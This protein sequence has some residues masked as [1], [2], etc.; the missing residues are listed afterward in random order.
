MIATA[1]GNQKQEKKDYMELMTKDSA[2]KKVI[3]HMQ[4]SGGDQ[5]RHGDDEHDV[6]EP[7]R[8]EN[9]ATQ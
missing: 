6:E 3:T 8:R 7:R 9:G 5:Q 4:K 1:T 2:S